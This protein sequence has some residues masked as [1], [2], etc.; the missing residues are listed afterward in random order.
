[1]SKRITI[2]AIDPGIQHLGWSIH[3]YDLDAKVDHILTFGLLEA[4]KQAKKEYKSEFTE[5]ADVL[6]LNIVTREILALCQKYQPAYASCERAFMGR[7]PTS[8]A[9]LSLC[10]SAIRQALYQYNKLKLYLVSPTEAKAAVSKGTANKEAVQYAVSH[11]ED[12]KLPDCDIENMS[13]HEADSVAI[14]YTFCT[15]YL[16]ELLLQGSKK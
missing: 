9:S 13:E 1:M 5:F 14:G 11:L 4:R 8:F 2:L 10:I 12:I 15:S 3:Q 7:F 6:P 16:D